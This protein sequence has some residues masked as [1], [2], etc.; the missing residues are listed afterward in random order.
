MTEENK[1]QQPPRS[2]NPG[3]Q[4][5]GAPRKP[6]VG[7][8]YILLLILALV[9]LNMFLSSR[10][11]EATYSEFLEHLEAGHIDWVQIGTDEI[12]GHMTIPAKELS[13]LAEAKS[14]LLQK[15]DPSDPQIPGLK[16]ESDAFKFMTRV[17]PNEIREDKVIELLKKQKVSILQKPDNSFWP[18][19]LFWILPL[20]LII[21]FWVMMMRQSGQLGRT[22]MSFG[23]TRAKLASD[24]KDAVDFGNVAGCDEAKEELQEVVD[25]LQDPKKFQT[26]GARMPKG[27]LL[28]GPP[29]TGKT[30]L[31]RAVAGEAGKPFFQLSG[32]DF[33]EMFVGVGAA[34]VRD[35]FQ[36]AKNKAPCIV[37]VDELDAVGRHRG[38]GLG[39]GHDEREQTLNQ[40][41]VEMDG[42]DAMSGVIFLAAT[43]RPDVLDPALLRPGR[44]DRQ[45][46]IDAPDRKGREEILEVHA[47]G[48][49]ID[50][51]IDLEYVAASTPGFTG[52]DL[53]NLLNEA[54]LLA[55]RAKKEQIT[56][57]E[58]DE[59]VDRVKAGPERK[60]LR[61]TEE[62]LKKTAYHEVGHALVAEVSE[63]AYP[64]RKITIVPRGRALGY[65]AL[66]P[67]EDTYS[68]HKDELLDMIKMMMGGRAAEMLVFGEQWTGAAN[69]LERATGV[70]R[71]MVCRFGMSD[72]LG[73]IVYGRENQQVFLGRDMTQEDRNYSEQSAQAIDAEVRSIVESAHESA[74]AILTKH[75]DCLDVLSEILIEK[76]TIAGKELDEILDRELGDARVKKKTPEELKEEKDA[77]G[78]TE[79]DPGSDASDSPEASSD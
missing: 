64:V 60:S 54:A 28:V 53:A 71:A 78:A 12:K 4:G 29:G 9:M 55:A 48:K 20:F 17:R 62:Q 43:N 19:F 21:A 50:E 67:E 66:V 47:K 45:V 34:R 24:G 16:Y 27:I 36:Q 58:I 30:L 13:D 35:L 51:D 79:D 7:L 68:Q 31:A 52:A 38:A 18:T 15:R 8:F 11:N 33:V 5:E 61:Q 70:A 40:L 26:L 10:H 65:T 73:P 37:F 42:F 39:G 69:D 56:Q 74:L 72:N 76:E 32:S 14:K 2:D 77:E 49:P 46:T 57:V 3:P 75:R 1:S 63:H 23:K 25:Y 22:A 6:R 59:A 44:F 41:L